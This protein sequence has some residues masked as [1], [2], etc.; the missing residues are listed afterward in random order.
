MANIDRA[1][2]RDLP[3]TAVRTSGNT[4][5]LGPT[6]IALVNLD[7]PKAGGYDALTGLTGAASDLYKIKF[8]NPLNVVSKWQSNHD[9]GTINFQKSDVV[10]LTVDVPGSTELKADIWTIGYNGQKGSGIKLNSDSTLTV[11]IELSGEPIELAGYECGKVLV[12][13]QLF[14]PRE[15]PSDTN[16]IKSVEYATTLEKHTMHE[17][18]EDAVERLKAKPLINGQKLGELVDIKI[19]TSVDDEVAT[20]GTLTEMRL[21]VPFGM[22]DQ[23]ELTDLQSK[24]PEVKIEY[25]PSKIVERATVYKFLVSGDVSAYK[26]FEYARTVT[27]GVDCETCEEGEDCTEDLSFNVTVKVEVIRELGIVAETF[28]ATIPD[29]KCGESQLEALQ[30]YYGATATI[31]EVADSI[32]ACARTYQAVVNGTLVDS[33]CEGTVNGSYFHVDLKSFRDFDWKKVNVKEYSEDTEMGIRI[34][35]KTISMGTDKPFNNDYPIIIGFTKMKVWASDELNGRRYSEV[36]GTNQ[37]QKITLVQRGS[38]PEGLGYEY[39]QSIVASQ[40]YFRGEVRDQGN[41]YYND[42]YLFDTPIKMHVPYITYIL[43]IQKKNDKVFSAG[44]GQG[45]NYRFIVELGKQAELETLLNSIATDA[46]LE[47]VEA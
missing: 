37:P 39:L 20:V 16:F 23:E 3:V 44:I 32:S 2:Y 17:I 40:A 45:V 33:K 35:G 19:V 38:K 28:Q 9:L 31:T 43:T 1:F 24:F 29:T 47:T 14:A 25:D 5:N 8:G 13:E 26:D 36:N 41:A 7:K 6:E 11:A 30:A 12:Q 27:N 10:G 46:G 15:L 22:G 21:I 42:T 34:E 4:K 18:I